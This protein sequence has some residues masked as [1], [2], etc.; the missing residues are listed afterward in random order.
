MI[1]YEDEFKNF[2]ASVRLDDVAEAKHRDRLERDLLRALTKRTPRQI[3]IWRAIMK[4]RMTKLATA[5]AVITMAVLGIIF[6]EKSATPAYGIMQT[7]EAMKNITTVHIFG[8]DWE[9]RQIEMWVKVNPDTALVEYCYLDELDAGKLTVSTPNNTCHY[10]RVSNTVRIEDGPAV[11]SIFRLGQFIEDMSELT[12]ALNGVISHYEAYDPDIQQ[13]VIVLQMISAQLDLKARIDPETKLPMSVN[14]IRG[15]KPGSY[16]ILKHADQIYYGE[17]LPEGL[18][19]FEI[20]EGATVVEETVKNAG[21]QLPDSV[22]KFVFDFHLET[23]KKATKATGIWVNSQLYLVDDRFNLTHG[24]FLGIY[25]DSNNTWTGE[26]SVCNTDAPNMA[27]FDK[28]GQKQKIRMVQRKGLPP[29][30]FRVYWQ[31]DEPLHPGQSRVGLYWAE[32]PKELSSKTTDGLYQLCMNNFVGCEVV[33]SF[34]LILPLDIEV[35][36]QSEDYT[37]H[38]EMDGFEIYIWQK[39]ICL[40][41]QNHVVDVLLGY[42]DLGF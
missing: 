18:F 12:K 40:P 30:R 10:D 15:Q 34:I 14:V 8:R 39:H 31:L 33:Q 2:V 7:I 29:G 3:K 17:F 9:D 5:A 16:E 32:N 28:A 37:S 38:K 24:G 4:T 25:N 22:I 36:K 35:R 11:S 21:Q 20:P 1:N 13:D 26:V 19:D 23:I 27:V 42:E 41:G 6:L